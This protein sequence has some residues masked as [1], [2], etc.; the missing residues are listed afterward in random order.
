MARGG[1]REVQI[2]QWFVKPGARVEQFQKLCEVQSDKANVEI[3]S[4]F[5]GVI[6]KLHYDA[7]DMAIVGK[8]LVD[9]DIQ[10]ELFPED[11]ALITPPEESAAETKSEDTI[12]NK[13]RDTDPQE[14][15][16][17]SNEVPAEQQAAP[18]KHPTLA[19]PAVRHLSRELNI[20]ISSIKGTGKDG[21]ILKED[22]QRFASV[23][24]DQKQAH[25]AASIE[26]QQQQTAPSEEDRIV[27]L[28]AVQMQMFKTMTKSLSIP[29]FLYT[30][31]VGLT[32]LNN[33][34]RELNNDSPSESTRGAKNTKD[35]NIRL[36]S[37]AFIVKALSL[38]LTEHPILNARL[39]IP[40][41]E[42]QTQTQ[43]R[44]SL[45]YRGPHNIGIAV[46]TPQG[47]LVP[48][49]K[50]VQSLTIPHIAASISRLSEQARSSQ[51]TASDLSG[52]TFTVSNVGSIG[53]GAVAPVIVEGQ[54]AILGVGRTRAVPAFDENGAVVRREECVLSW[55]ADHRV[56]DG[57]TVARCAELV[58]RSLERP[59]AMC[60]RMR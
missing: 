7:D 37:L 13:G 28:S 54:V 16:V 56:V 33:L 31:S 11:E 21:R 14:Q 52:G 6:Q 35:D 55:S 43:P 59:E 50:N 46:D 32:R 24:G 58:K 34:R 15:A 25:D 20:D 36:S 41:P 47:L 4:R 57:A 51:L 29:H 2:I 9:I 5:D 39:E 60:V 23:H 3:T 45:A 42:P 40:S 30:D 53:G 19:T 17:A 22:V 48:V 49:L 44:P 18:T 1:I 27:P 8:P 12:S 38:A 10:S 26:Q